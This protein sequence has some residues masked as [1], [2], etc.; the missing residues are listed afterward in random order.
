VKTDYMGRKLCE[1]CW[2]GLHYL[3]RT[4]DGKKL[5]KLS[6]CDGGGCECPCRQLLAE[7]KERA[8][9]RARERVR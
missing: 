3:H 4:K 6:Q 2:N 8:A 9:K 7:E 1:P 5:E